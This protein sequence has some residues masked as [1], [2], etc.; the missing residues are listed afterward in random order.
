MPICPFRSLFFFLFFCNLFF[1]TRQVIL[2]SSGNSI[3][4]LTFHFSDPNVYTVLCTRVSLPC[5]ALNT[6]TFFFSFLPSR[7]SC[8]AHFYSLPLFSIIEQ[9]PAIKAKQQP[10]FMQMP[11]YLLTGLLA[12]PQQLQ[13]AIIVSFPLH[14]PSTHVFLVTHNTG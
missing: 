6:L 13:I 8:L 4:C 5:L 10:I 1:L 9:L 3:L 2:S 12:R 14:F 11:K 7:R